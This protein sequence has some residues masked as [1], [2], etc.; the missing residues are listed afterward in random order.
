MKLERLYIQGFKSFKD[1]TTIHFDDGITGIVGPNGCGKSNIVDALFWVM[2]EQSAKHLRGTKMSDLIFSG[3]K[4]YSPGS[5]AEVTLVLSNTGKK[6]IHI[7]SKVVCPTEI[8]LTRKLYRSGDT[9]YKINNTTARLKDIQEVFMDTGAGAKSYSI[10]AQGEIDRLVKAKPVER[11]VMIEEVAG[12]TKFKARK[13]ESLRKIEQ[14]NTNLERIN[15]LKREIHKNLKSLEAQS[16]KAEKAKNLKEKVQR[17]FLIV[18]SHKELEYLEKINNFTTSISELEKVIEDS[19][20]ELEAIDASLETEKN[21]KILLMDQLE[22]LQADFNEASIKLVSNEEKLNFSQS[23]IVEKNQYIEEKEEELESL[24]VDLKRG[25]ERFLEIKQALESFS[26]NFSGGEGES[27][28]DLEEEVALL[29]NDLEVTQEEKRSLDEEL[30]NLKLSFDKLENEQ[31]RVKTQAQSKAGSIEEMVSEIEELENYY[32]EVNSGDATQRQ[33]LDKIIAQRDSSREQLSK[34][35][36]KIDDL[37]TKVEGVKSEMANFKN[38]LAG[39]EA[40]KESLE[41]SLA[42]KSM[43]DVLE[44]FSG[45]GDGLL[46]DLI[47]VK[48]PYQHAVMSLLEPYLHLIV[49]E[50]NS[51]EHLFEWA[52]ENN[53]NV[54][55]LNATQTHDSFAPVGYKTLDEIV[56]TQ[57]MSV[58]NFLKYF[59][60]SES[61]N[62]AQEMVLDIKGTKFSAASDISG[63]NVVKGFDENLVLDFRFESHGKNFLSLKAKLDQIIAEIVDIN[64]NLKV[65]ESELE[66]HYDLKSKLEIERKDFD[67]Q[68]KI[69][70]EK[71]IGLEAK[72]NSQSHQFKVN[73]DRLG[74]LKKKSR[75]LSEER[76]TLVE[77]DE[78]IITDIEDL[79]EKLEVSSEKQSELSDKHQELSLVYNQRLEKYLEVKSEFKSLESR[80]SSFEKDLK[81]LELTKDRN[82]ERVKSYK[83]SIEN[84]QTAIEELSQNEQDYSEVIEEL[85]SGLKDQEGTLSQLKDD[86]AILLSAMQ[87]REKQATSLRAVISKS[88]KEMSEKSIKLEKVYEDEELVTRNTFD[89]YKIDLRNSIS[90]HLN[91]N[92][93][94][95]LK[96]VSDMFYMDGE[97]ESIRIEGES[98]DFSKRFPGQVKESAEKL[99][100]YKSQL[101]RLGSINWQA[102]EDYDK[103]KTRHDFLRSQEEELNKSIQDLMSA[104]EHIDE[105]SKE[106]FSVAY[107]EVNSKF[108]QVFPIIFGGGSATLKMVGNI[109][110]DDNFG[111]EIIA[112]PPGKKMQN[113]NLMS[114]G[115][116][117]LTAVALI[118]SIFLVKPSPFCLLDEVDAPLDDANVGRFNQLLREMSN[119]SQFILITHNKK[120][121][122]L[123]DR[124]YGITMQEPGVSKAL[125]VQLQ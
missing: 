114:G 40:K 29:K 86:L 66:E 68:A 24:Q 119:E 39:L 65:Q 1:R 111:V 48:E 118:F 93:E 19:S 70:N 72:L 42:E 59:L 109:D 97:V 125:S 11:R 20:V 102:V 36:L 52:K 117:A 60:I 37:N 99:K 94:D 34:H 10:I 32:L 27:L 4:K 122:E 50:E 47:K 49:N 110:E 85:T 87:E 2:G 115:E 92:L 26:E 23:S 28:K 17:H 74:A 121:M 105:K 116:K 62:S 8:Q 76:F 113:I 16:E 55:V 6:H 41:E 106:R 31:I 107:E 89:Q 38:Q 63:Q 22:Q 101:N 120:T 100:N 88:D 46:K 5:F 112:S 25:E 98:Y 69:L 61:D 83:Q 21:E 45:R 53:R 108:T 79:K 80:K 7:G 13:K 33:E 64:E 73:G 43:S 14:T 81:E 124:L 95:K 57:S 18:N 71:T 30:S 67:E 58:K 123:N 15:D 84:N 9:E 56:E 104:I 54:S 35:Q 96:D 12:I 103:Q 91:I 51:Y 90:S 3:S 82:L 78:S 77:R 44:K 75:Q